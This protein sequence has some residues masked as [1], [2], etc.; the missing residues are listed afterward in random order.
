MTLNTTSWKSTFTVRPIQSRFAN[1]STSTESER[2]GHLAL[3]KVTDSCLWEVSK[4]RRISQKHLRDMKEKLKLSLAHQ[5]T[6]TRMDVLMQPLS[7]TTISKIITNSKIRTVHPTSARV[8]IFVNIISYFKALCSISKTLTW[9]R[10]VFWMKILFL[11]QSPKTIKLA[12]SFRDSHTKAQSTRPT[13]T[14]S[15]LWPLMLTLNLNALLMP[16]TIIWCLM[17]QSLWTC[18]RQPT[19]ISMF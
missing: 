6:S 5:R 17:I 15:S 4:K 8:K 19:R 11:I 16:Q 3:L 10:I 2:A 1:C 12:V 18:L 9:S 14:T 7:R 13:I